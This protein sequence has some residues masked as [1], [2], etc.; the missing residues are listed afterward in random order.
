MAL[1]M[2]KHG[3]L[4]DIVRQCG[5]FAYKWY[6]YMCLQHHYTQQ[7]CCW[8]IDGSVVGWFYRK[9]LQKYQ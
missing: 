2:I 7:L 4:P 9:H 5:Y 1:L 8:F 3:H 6:A